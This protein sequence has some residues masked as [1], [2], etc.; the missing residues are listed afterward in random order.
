MNVRP[1]KLA[2]PLLSLALAT[3]LLAPAVCCAALAPPLP[4]ATSAGM[5]APVPATVPVSTARLLDIAGIEGVRSNSLVGYGLVVGLNG[6]GDQRQSLFTI[7]TLANVLRRLGVQYDVTQVQMHNTAAVFVTA[8]LPPFARPGTRLDVTVSSIGD[9]KSI[10]GGLLLLTPLLGPNGVVYADAQ[11]A[12]TMGGFSAGANGNSV[13]VN[14]ANIGII[15]DGGIVERGVDV[16]LSGMKTLNLLLHQPDFATAASAV[17][18]INSALGAP[19]AHAVDSRCIA[20]TPPAGVSVPVLLARIEDLPVVVHARA[21]VVV[22]ERTGTIVLGQ[23]VTLGAV[24]ILHGNLSI[25]IST[26]YQVSQPSPFSTG[27]QTTVVPKT[28]VKATESPTG[29]IQLPVGATVA[30]LV[31]GLQ[32]MNA[33]ARDVVAILQALQAAGALHADLKV[34]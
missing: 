18:A 5:P 29:T 12:L 34:I 32:A 33:S 20:V 7:Q 25:Q 21:E 30:D 23:N 26:Q 2:P 6:T 19:D 3:A 10:E 13:G 1:M 16:N 14:K 31:R 15:P 22:D 4:A 8:Q 17:D 11:G 27:G 28:D 24:A 9:A